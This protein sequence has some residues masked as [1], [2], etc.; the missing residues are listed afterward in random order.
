MPGDKWTFFK[1]YGVS[2]HL[3]EI[4][5][6]HLYE[7]TGELKNRGLIS[8]NHYLV[9]KD[10]DGIH[11][12]IRY[13]SKS[14]TKPTELMSE[15]NKWA[16]FLIDSGLID[17]IEFD[18]Y[19]RE[20]E[21]YG[22]IN[23]MPAIEHVFTVDS[24]VSTD[25]LRSLPVSSNKTITAIMTIID[26]LNFLGLD[27]N[28]QEQLVSQ[29]DNPINRRFFKQARKELHDQSE[30][31]IRNILD[32]TNHPENGRLPRDLFLDKA[33]DS[34]IEKSKVNDMTYL[35]LIHMHCN[36]LLISRKQEERIMYLLA[37]LLNKTKLFRESGGSI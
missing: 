15:I 12:R 1:L 30:M 26:Y 19:Q 9:Y 13:K 35:S 4:I 32:R 27:L 23:F 24:E 25:I 2:N 28:H 16:H 8:E 37:Y 21:R 36:R 22:G 20:I 34:M 7:F 3:T 18:T 5:S 33:K 29:F 14:G 11:L 17:R 10:E 6:N 31:L